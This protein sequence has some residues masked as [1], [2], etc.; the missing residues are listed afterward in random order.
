M[1]AKL[2][3]VGD[4]PLRLYFTR[5]CEKSGLRDALGVRSLVQGEINSIGLFLARSEFPGVFF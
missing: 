4:V 5:E 2:G 1:A 3:N